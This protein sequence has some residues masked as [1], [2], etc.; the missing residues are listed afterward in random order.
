MSQ[1]TVTESSFITDLGAVLDPKFAQIIA[2]IRGQIPLPVIDPI[3]A[4][5]NR[6]GILL[7]DMYSGL[8]LYNAP[9]SLFLLT[10]TTPVAG[11]PALVINQS[12]STGIAGIFPR[13]GTD[14]LQITVVLG[15]AVSGVMSVV[16]TK[17]GVALSST[18]NSG[19]A[20]TVGSEYSFPIVVDKSEEINFSFNVAVT[21]QR[22]H[23]I[24]TM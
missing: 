13:R 15:G 6:L 17:N 1:T 14:V 22:L 8:V 5:A 2:A 4:A 24:E 12:S 9:I 19:V 21:L 10:N 3:Q 23:I 7:S 16:R 11:T 18:L 20:L